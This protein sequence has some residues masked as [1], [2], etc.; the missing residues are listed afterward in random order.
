MN[1]LASLSD[2]EEGEGKKEARK[3]GERIDACVDSR[4][5]AL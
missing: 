4:E 2:K 3:K 1:D 5:I